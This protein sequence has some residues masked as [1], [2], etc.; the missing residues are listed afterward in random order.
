MVFLMP[1]QRGAFPGVSRMRLLL[2][3]D[4]S[5][6]KTTL[7]L[8][9]DGKVLTGRS[10]ANHSD[11]SFTAFMAVFLLPYKRTNMDSDRKLSMHNRFPEFE[12]V[13]VDHMA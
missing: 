13:F 1:D 5:R 10:L 7:A 11:F 12:S 3:L 9:I 6:I 4:R 8:A 2:L